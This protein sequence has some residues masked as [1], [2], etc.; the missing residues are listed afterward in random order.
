MTNPGTF[1]SFKDTRRFV[2]KTFNV[3]EQKLEVTAS[4]KDCGLVWER[5]AKISLPVSVTTRRKVPV[6]S[7]SALVAALFNSRTVYMIQFHLFFQADISSSVS[8][9][10]HWNQCLAFFLT[11]WTSESAFFFFKSH[12]QSQPFCPWDTFQLS[13]LM[14]SEH[15]PGRWT[16]AFHLIRKLLSSTIFAST[17]SPSLSFTVILL[18]T[19][20]EGKG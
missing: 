8:L 10:K 6:G 2:F 7:L 9:S 16:A 3:T 19:D 15:F 18:S 20:T 13:V 11:L 14:P 12:L 17:A 1:F 5:L 4:D